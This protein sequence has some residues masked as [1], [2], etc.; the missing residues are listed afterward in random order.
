M[1]GIHPH[2]YLAGQF[3]SRVD[4]FKFV[5][6]F[7]PTDRFS[8]STGMNFNIIGISFFCRLDLFLIR[9]DKQT[10]DNTAIF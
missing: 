7:V 10:D 8:I 9:I 3:D 5:L 4:M 6:L 1:T 2:T